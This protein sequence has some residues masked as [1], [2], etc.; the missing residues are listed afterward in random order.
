MRQSSL[1]RPVAI[2]QHEPSVPPGLIADVFQETGRPYRTVEAWGSTDRP[3]L[4]DVSGLVVM[5]GTMNVDAVDDH[6]FVIDSRVLMSQALERD[7]PVLGV[8]LG[9]QMMARVLGEEV[10]RAEPR[11]AFFSPLELTDEGRSDP[12][13]GHFVGDVPVL[14]FHEDTF[15]IPDGAVALATSARSGLSQAFRFGERAYAIQFHFEVDR[16]IVAG[17]CSNIGEED[18]VSEWGTA[19]EDLLSEVDEHLAA[20][21][22]AGRDLVRSWLRLVE[23]AQADRLVG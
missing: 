21:Q 11:N 6:P 9:S 12:L 2:V 22:R 18:M 17:W 3:D 19:T 10:F 14:Q 13:L 20:Q 15:A 16:A 8:C 5:G 4:D 1:E 7:V 23:A